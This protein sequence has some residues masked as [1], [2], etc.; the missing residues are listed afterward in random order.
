MK[1]L[2]FLTLLIAFLAPLALQ[3]NVLERSISIVGHGLGDSGVVAAAKGGTQ[4]AQEVISSYKGSHYATTVLDQD[5][6]LTRVYGGTSSELGS[7]WSR[8]TYSSAGRAQQ[9][10]ALPPGNTA[11]N[12]V[13]IRVPAGTTIFEGKAASAFGKLGG[14][15]QVYIPQVNPSWIVP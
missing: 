1:R 8:T 14:G 10:L 7:F 4:L 3:A 15:N 5:V 12:V 2:G 13:R 9:Y 11:E 6:I